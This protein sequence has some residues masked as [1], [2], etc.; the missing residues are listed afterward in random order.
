MCNCHMQLHHQLSAMHK[1]VST[2]GRYP[3]QIRSIQKCRLCIFVR[4]G[5][6]SKH[7]QCIFLSLENGATWGST[8]L[9]MARRILSPS[10]LVNLI[11]TGARQLD[12]T[13]ETTLSIK[14]VLATWTRALNSKQ[15]AILSDRYIMYICMY[16]NYCIIISHKL[17]WKYTQE[18]WHQYQPHVHIFAFLYFLLHPLATI[19]DSFQVY[20]RRHKDGRLLSRSFW[21]ANHH[22]HKDTSAFFFWLVCP[23]H[24]ST[25]TNLLSQLSHIQSQDSF[26]YLG[27]SIPLLQEC[28]CSFQARQSNLD[29]RAQRHPR[30]T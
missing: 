12:P 22:R 14:V 30:K 16:M 9:D 13:H 1:G 25:H 23:Q 7:K 10:A 3:L 27:R 4:Q 18:V 11:L 8:W 26:A 19:N 20:W 5:D 29:E 6:P 17:V 28:K 2:S 21:G 24:P 15:I